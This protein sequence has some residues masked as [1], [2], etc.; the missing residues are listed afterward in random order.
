MMKPPASPVRRAVQVVLASFALLGSALVLTGCGGSGTDPDAIGRTG[1][2]IL[3]VTGVDEAHRGSRPVAYEGLF[4]IYGIEVQSARGFTR[5]E[6]MAI[7][8][9]QVRADFPVG[10][11]DRVFDGPRLSD[12]LRVAGLEGA[13]V[14]LTSFDGYEAEVPAE[15]IARYEP[16]LAL[17]VN[18]EPLATGG[19]GPVMLVWPRRSQGTLADMNDDLWPWGVFAITPYV[20]SETP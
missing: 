9:R 18:G 13:S 17:R 5:P 3:V 19:L 14:R 20:P 6:L 8:W 7:S 1:P 15:M 12:V 4:A 2:V 11:P 10:S 16:I